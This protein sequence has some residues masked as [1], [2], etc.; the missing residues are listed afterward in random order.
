ML[1]KLKG[2]RTIVLNA[3]LATA[4]LVLLVLDYAQTVDVST[5]FSPVGVLAYTVFVHVANI[6]LRYIT[7]TPVGAQEAQ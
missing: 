5:V 7:T 4:P 2:W 1:A 6:G 3:A